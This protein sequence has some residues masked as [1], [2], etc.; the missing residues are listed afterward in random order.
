MFVVTCRCRA[1]SFVERVEKE[2]NVKNDDVI[3]QVLGESPTTRT[4]TRKR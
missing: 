1:T 2:T 4:R 3:H